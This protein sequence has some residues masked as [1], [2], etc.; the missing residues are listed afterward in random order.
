MGGVAGAV[1]FQVEFVRSRWGGVRW[2]GWV[3]VGE[4]GGIGEV[5]E[6][7]GGRWGGGWGS[8][9]VEIGLGEVVEEG[10]GVGEGKG[11]EEGGLGPAFLLW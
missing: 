8:G 1:E 7:G 11:R 9:M 6:V 2:V 10:G 3:R 4:V 5:G